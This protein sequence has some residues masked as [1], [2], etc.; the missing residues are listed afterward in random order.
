MSI[1][2][3]S[4][5]HISMIIC[6]PFYY[7]NSF[8]LGHKPKPPPMRGTRLY[9]SRCMQSFCQNVYDRI[10]EILHRSILHNSFSSLCYSQIVL[11]SYPLYLPLHFLC[12]GCS[13]SNGY[14]LFFTIFLCLFQPLY[15]ICCYFRT[16]IV[17]AN[18]IH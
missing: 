12:P 6:L 13:H 11:S 9:A 8:K 2:A 5:Y 16:A 10:S 4:L 1:E 18:V 14:T 3:H 15:A 7:Y 17:A